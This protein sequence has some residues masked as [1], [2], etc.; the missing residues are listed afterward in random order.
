MTDQPTFP[1]TGWRPTRRGLIRTGLAAGVTVGL[2]T[3]TAAA[4]AGARPLTIPALRSWWPRDGIWQLPATPT[5]L[6]RPIDAPLLAPGARLFAD[7]LGTRTGRS[8]TVEVSAR[9]AR[10]GDI[11]LET[12]VVD[13][14]GAGSHLIDV[15]RQVVVRAGDVA[16]VY[17]GTRTLLQLL[18][19][20]P[21]I[22]RG[23]AQD[24]PRYAE[25]GVMIDIGRKYF[26]PEWL[27]DLV[28]ELGYLKM[29]YLHLHLTD[30]EGFRIENERYPQVVS[31]QHLTKADVHGLLDIA[32]QHQ[33]TLVP[34]IDMPGHMTA[35]LAAFP[36]FQL[37]DVFGRASAG[38]LDFTIPEARAWA[39]ELLAEYLDLFPG[40]YLHVGADEFLP[41][42][43]Y[44]LYPQIRAY[45]RQK[46]GDQANE[47]DAFLDF[48]NE[49]ATLLRQHGKRL[50]VWNDGLGG[51]S[52][53]EL[54]D[55][56]VVDWWND[57]STLG[58]TLDVPLP[59]DLVQDG[60]LVQNAGWWPTYYVNGVNGTVRPKPDVRDMYERWDVHEFR[61]E[62]YVTTDVALPEHELEPQD[63]RVLGSILHVWNDQPDSATPDEI[64][65]GIAPR[66]RVLAQKTWQSP[67]LVRTYAEFEQVM[68]VVGGVPA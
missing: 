59:A 27:A 10:E 2:L 63:P 43:A 31:Q 29:D 48:L 51:A 39:K 37:R 68:A 17:Y 41:E 65:A 23:A 57:V 58:G 33:V 1:M 15:D 32:R 7:E 54:S 50:R 34:E 60:H 30:N 67:S 52:V 53:V 20:G 19:Q 9:R 25:R 18:G 55:D 22:P 38:R 42:P 26:T 40:P 24:R 36:Q 45:A 6:V 44:P 11:V 47:K 62:L 28:R 61:G 35:A 46:H 14:P 64:A 13:H 8:S 3:P 56:I 5:V 66:L 49:I 12:G 4:A 16:G 21:T